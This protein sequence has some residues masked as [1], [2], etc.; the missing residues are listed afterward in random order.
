MLKGVA[1][2]LGAG[3]VATGGALAYKGLSKPTTHSVKDLLSIKNPEKR[4]ISK[5]LG[6]S[7]EEWKA[8][9]KLYA[10]DYKNNDKNPFSLTTEKP[11]TDPD[12]KQE[13]STEFIDK[14]VSLSVGQVVDEKD[15]SYR[16]VLKYCTR[17]TL[18]KDLI[19]E[20]H[21]NRKIL[22]NTG[23]EDAEGWKAAWSRYKQR[24][25][26]QKAQGNDEWKLTDWATH[27]TDDAPNGLK[28]KC[29]EK[30]KLEIF[31][32]NHKDYKDTVDWCTN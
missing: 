15:N 6:G 29:G 17:A 23:S 5:S 30:I 24:N 8:A 4:L 10:L 13:A 25:P 20:N 16:D 3:A 11:T 22:S 18:I 9:W 26:A 21:P 12:G 7:S 28:T 31:D 1:G 19:S 27:S 2:V 14:C 32:T